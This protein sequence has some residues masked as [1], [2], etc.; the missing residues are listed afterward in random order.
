MLWCVVNA[1]LCSVGD[2]DGDSVGDSVGDL[3]GDSVGCSASCSVACSVA[4]SVG[5]LSVSS[6]ASP[7]AHAWAWSAAGLSKRVLPSVTGS[8]LTRASCADELPRLVAD[9]ERQVL[10]RLYLVGLL[11]A[12]HKWVLLAADVPAVNIT[13]N[14]RA[15]VVSLSSSVVLSCLGTAA[16]SSPH[17]R[18]QAGGRSPRTSTRR[19]G[20]TAPLSL[21]R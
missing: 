11:L 15:C 3:V 9:S 7:W 12:S 14:V 6:R 20:C 1:G 17:A 4:C 2:S 5:H 18:R 10:P 13:S 21:L 8:N 19:R 16:S